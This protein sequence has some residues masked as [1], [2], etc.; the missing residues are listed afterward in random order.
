MRCGSTRTTASATSSPA[1]CCGPLLDSR[2]R[3]RERRGL[4]R[5]GVAA[6]AGGLVLS[7]GLRVETRSADYEDTRRRALLSARHDAGRAPVACR[8]GSARSRGWYVD[9]EPRL[10]G[11]RIQHRRA[12]ARRTGASSSPS[13]CGTSRAA[14]A[15]RARTARCRASWRCSTCGASRSRWRPRSSSIRATRCPTS[16]TRTTRRAAAT[17]G[18]EAS[19][20]VACTAGA[21]ARRH[22]RAAALGVPRLS[23]RRS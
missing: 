4:R 20:R 12:R 7:S 8:A 17:A 1:S 15:T 5:G 21:H 23:L 22:A 9:R 18:L 6:S 3:G 16:S 10:Q 13:T 19:A 14:C 11:R 2:L